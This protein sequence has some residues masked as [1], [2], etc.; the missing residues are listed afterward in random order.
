MPT[1]FISVSETR[2][3]NTKTALKNQ[4]ASIQGLET[5]IGQLSKLI[6]ERPQ[7]S[8]PSNIEPNPREQLNAINIQ[9]D[10]GVV[11]PE[12]KLRQE[13]VVSKGQG[14][15]GHNKNKSVNVEYK[16]R[17]PYHNAKKKDRSDEQFGELTLRV[18]DETI[19]LQARNSGNTLE[20]EG[21]RLNYSTKT[22]SMVQPSLQEMSLKEVHEPF[23]SNSRGPI[24]EDRRLQI[25]ELDEWQTHKSRTPDKPN[26]RQSEL[27]TFP[28]QLK[29]GDRVLLDVADPH[30]V[31]TTSNEEIPLAVLSIFPFGKIEVSHP[32]FKNF[33]S[34]TPNVLTE[35]LNIGFPQRHDQ[36]HGRA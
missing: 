6:S 9:D 16:P 25:K 24:H 1:K 27:N 28:N 18:G 10:E 20:I 8:L 34:S 15:V 14:E 22:D 12:P 26:L 19:T 29:V 2:F 7:G 17:V 23:L 5:Q 31:T 32:K 11:E 21:D 30:I 36:A 3:K 33:K 13:N 4:Q 35:L